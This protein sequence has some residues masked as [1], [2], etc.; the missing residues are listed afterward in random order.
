MRSG[1][2]QSKG[3]RKTEQTRETTQLY[4]VSLHLCFSFFLACL[5]I[6]LHYSGV[7]FL[8]AV[9]HSVLRSFI[10]FLRFC[11]LIFQ[12]SLSCIT[13]FLRSLSL[14]L[15]SRSLSLLT[16]RQG[17]IVASFPPSPFR[18]WN[19]FSQTVAQMAHS[20]QLRISSE[21]LLW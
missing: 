8:L 13:V 1:K 20:L 9:S 21:V 19:P 4:F 17:R 2:G 7:I 10:I 14:F 18:M 16:R 6:C 15:S 5:F 11:E 3:K 12:A